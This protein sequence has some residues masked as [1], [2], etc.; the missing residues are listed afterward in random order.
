M[1]RAF[2]AR[3]ERVCTTMPGAGVRMQEA[4]STRS[5]STSTMQTRQLPSGRYPGAS[6]WHRCGMRKPWPLE[7]SQIVWP[8]S[9]VTSWPSR[10]KV[11]GWLAADMATVLLGSGLHGAVVEVRRLGIVGAADLVPEVLDGQQDR[12]RR[13][14]AEAAD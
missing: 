1:A 2:V 10:V 14:L 13:R 3:S 7:T 8:G 12:V 9:A 11:I 5:P 6:A 4:A